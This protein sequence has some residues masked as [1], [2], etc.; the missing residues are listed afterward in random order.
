MYLFSAN[1]NVNNLTFYV[2]IRLLKMTYITNIV[3]ISF[4]FKNSV[5]FYC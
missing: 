2:N 3:Y 4:Y 5:D 1:Y